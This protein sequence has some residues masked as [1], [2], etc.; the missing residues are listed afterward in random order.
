MRLPTRSLTRSSLRLMLGGSGLV[1]WLLMG[2][3]RLLWLMQHRRHR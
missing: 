3:W 1:A 2:P